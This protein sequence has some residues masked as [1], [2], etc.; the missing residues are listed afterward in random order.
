MTPALETSGLRL[1]AY[2]P[3]HDAQTVAWLNDPEIQRSF[4]L[5][6]RLTNESHRAWVE[7]NGDY[8]IWAI[9]GEKDEHFG[10]ILRQ[11]T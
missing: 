8:L 4:G 9:A 7:A 2:G 5:A 11:P 10:N 6:R 1:L 3:E